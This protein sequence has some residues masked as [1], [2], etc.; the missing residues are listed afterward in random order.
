MPDQ[1]REINDLLDVLEWYA[2]QPDHVR[3]EFLSRVR[4]LPRKAKAT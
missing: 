2:E 4:E 1:P 3:A